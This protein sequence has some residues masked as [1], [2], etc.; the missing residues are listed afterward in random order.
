MAAILS[1]QY[2][3]DFVVGAFMAIFWTATAMV[4]LLV[5]FQMRTSV[6]GWS[7]PEALVVIGFF[8]ALKGVMTGLMQPSLGSV[9]E[10]IRKGTLDFLLLKPADAQLLVST[11][12]IDLAR[13]TDVIAGFGV[14][15]Y[16]AVKSGGIPSVQMVLFSALMLLAGMGVLY[17]FWVLAVSLAFYVVKVDNLSYLIVSTFDAARWPSTIFRGVLS[18]LFTFVIPLA[19]MTTFPALA[20]LGRLSM[21]D[22]AIS[23]GASAVFLSV[24]RWVW[25]SAVG[26]YTSAGG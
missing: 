21:T 14:A 12:K 20:L 13:S 7:F 9:V 23:L 17:S 8:T 3:L 18:F 6:A 4:P 25:V 15:L 10:H 1:L 5:L 16:G 24:S 22:A 11:S 19:L 2:R 26:K